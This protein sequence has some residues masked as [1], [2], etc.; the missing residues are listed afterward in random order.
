MKG[1]AADRPSLKARVS[2]PTAR[3][4]LRGFA[5]SSVAR[6]Y[7][8]PDFT[9]RRRRTASARFRRTGTL[10]SQPMQASVML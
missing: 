10:S 5:M 4:A 7:E 1:S 2:A 8:S 3:S 6:L 9:R